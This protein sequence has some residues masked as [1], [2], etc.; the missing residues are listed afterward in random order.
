M[1]KQQLELSR[2]PDR[3]EDVG[4]A[5][6]MLGPDAHPSGRLRVVAETS[7]IEV[8]WVGRFGAVWLPIPL[9]SK[10]DKGGLISG[11]EGEPVKFNG[12]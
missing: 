3:K 10:K 4:Y 2:I 5:Q 12:G 6:G 9:V 1:P 11:H 7:R 8:E